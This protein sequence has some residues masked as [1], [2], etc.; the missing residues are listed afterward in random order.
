LNFT[1]NWNVKRIAYAASFG[2]DNWEYTEFETGN[3]KKLV[4]QFDAVS[5][6]EQSAI[7]LCKNNFEVNVTQVLDPTMLLDV[8]HYISLIDNAKIERDNGNLFVYVLDRNVEINKIEQRLVADFSYKSFYSTANDGH[9]ITVEA[10]LHSFYNAEFILTDSFHACVFAILF[11]KPFIVLGNERR[12]MGRFNSLL[13]LFNLNERL[14]FDAKNVTEILNLPINW[15]QVNVIL[16]KEKMHSL[17][18]LENSLNNP[19]FH[20]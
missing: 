4:A 18:F 10:W 15:S 17:A 6:R 19:I 13:K 14:L 8:K 12:G 1:Q 11:N 2:T 5:V 9:P 3:C 20:I 16:E 7:K